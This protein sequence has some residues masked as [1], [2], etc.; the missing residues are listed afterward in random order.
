MRGVG[1]EIRTYVR[2]E[3]R[4]VRLWRWRGKKELGRGEYRERQGGR[5]TRRKRRLGCRKKG[6][7]GKGSKEVK[8]TS[9]LSG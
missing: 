5:N 7:D 6:E 2:Q 1:M 8:G 4:W 9:I 3:V